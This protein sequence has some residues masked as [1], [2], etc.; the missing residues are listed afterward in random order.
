MFVNP[1]FFSASIDLI[2]W[3]ITT[4]QT[5]A[6]EPFT[7]FTVVGTGT[8]SGWALAGMDEDRTIAVAAGPDTSDILSFM[9]H[10]DGAMPMESGA[11]EVDVAVFSNGGMIATAHGSVVVGGG[12]YSS[13]YFDFGLG[14]WTPEL[15][16]LPMA[17][18]PA[19]GALLLGAMGLGLVGVIARRFM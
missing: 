10:F 17:S 16:D 14:D 4:P 15:G 19:P 3:Q 5:F 6:T 2:A 11:I 18:A 7:D 12:A 8:T 13:P 9:L 1:A